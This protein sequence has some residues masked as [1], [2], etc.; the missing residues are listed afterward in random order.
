MPIYSESDLARVSLTARE[1]ESV[2]LLS[3]EFPPCNGGISRLCG[4]VARG[5]RSRGVATYIVTDARY[6]GRNSHFDGSIVGVGPTRIFRE[7]SALGRLRRRSGLGL[8]IC[9]SWYPEGLLALAAGARPLVVFAHGLELLPT[10]SAWRRNA[11]S[12]LRRRVLEEADLVVANSE[13]TRQ[14]ATR[15]APRAKVVA[16]PLGVDHQR[17]CPGDK[18]LAKQHFGVEGRFVVSTVSRLWA[19]KGHGT[20]LRAL[21]ALP[22]RAK[23]RIIYLIAGKGPFGGELRRLAHDLGLA[24][25]VRFLD[26]VGEEHL[27][28][29]YRASDLFVLCTRESTSQQEVEGFGLVFLEAQAC[30]TPVVGT[31]TGGIPEAVRE[32]EGGWLIDQNDS[33]ALA[34]IVARLADDAAPFVR[35]GAAARKRIERDCTWDLYMQRF[36]GILGTSG[37]R[38]G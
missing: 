27:P 4:E 34:Q 20:V 7:C 37:V 32:G 12:V 31:R 16:L 11:W 18:D 36:L 29:L 1:V 14:I 33:A 23:S 26:F 21:A 17:F 24:R 28:E 2:T 15:S 5:L 25:Q 9:G 30:G 10:R 13:Y 35:A 3:F 22:E 19:Y 8:V 6:A 38:L